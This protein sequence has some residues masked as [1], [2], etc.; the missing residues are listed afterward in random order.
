MDAAKQGDRRGARIDLWSSGVSVESVTAE[1]EVAGIDAPGAMRIDPGRGPDRG[2][3]CVSGPTS[4]GV[5][6]SLGLG[7]NV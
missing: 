7:A 5:S 1:R 2:I 4:P 6:R 3:V